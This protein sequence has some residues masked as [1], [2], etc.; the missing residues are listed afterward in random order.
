MILNPKVSCLF[1]LLE[2]KAD[3]RIHAS[4]SVAKAIWAAAAYSACREPVASSVTCGDRALRWLGTGLR[5]G[6]E[7]GYRSL[8]NKVIPGARAENL[9]PAAPLDDEAATKVALAL[10][11]Q[12]TLR[13][14]YERYNAGHQDVFPSPAPVASEA[15]VV[16]LRDLLRSA[17]RGDLEARRTILQASSEIEAARKDWRP[18]RS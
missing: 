7:A 12:T 14:L 18:L 16:R 11:K 15:F 6:T 8:L 10:I 3:G 17:K 5:P 2:R 9:L 13:N 1:D 4:P